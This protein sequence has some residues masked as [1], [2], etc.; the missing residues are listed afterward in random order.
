[1]LPSATSAPPEVERLLVLSPW[2]NLE[3]GA[4]M[5]STGLSV[6]RE[7]TTGTC[8]GF[9]ASSEER[10]LPPLPVLVSGEG[11]DTRSYRKS[12]SKFLSMYHPPVSSSVVET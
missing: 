7:D 10:G 11:V 1:M 2:G 3:E 9:R 12:R 6:I 8:N 4:L 5:S